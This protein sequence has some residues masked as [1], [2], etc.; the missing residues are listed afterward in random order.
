MFGE[1][2]SQ[3]EME[4]LLAAMTRPRKVEHVLP[5]IADGSD[6]SRLKKLQTVHDGLAAGF[7]A[8]LGPMLRAPV[9]VKLV[10]VDRLFYSEFVFAVDDPTYV[11]LIQ[12]TSNRET[13]TVAPLDDRLILE[14]GPSILFPMIERMLGGGFESMQ[15]RYRRPLTRIET[16]MAFRLIDVFLDELMLAWKKVEKCTFR[17]IQ[18]ESDP[19]FIQLC[20]PK[21][22]IVLLQ[23]EIRLPEA[24]GLLNLCIPASAKLLDT[25]E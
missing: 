5:P 6:K 18:A 13:E 3:E 17:A 23:F 7:A 14:V 15:Y 11:N 10:A 8:R 16:R 20:E 12:A 9:G 2:L 21:D 4:S 19:R 1:A 25:V 22:E 24:A